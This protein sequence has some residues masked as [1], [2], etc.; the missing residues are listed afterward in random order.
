MLEAEGYF[1]NNPKDTHHHENGVWQLP[2][3]LRGS[4]TDADKARYQE[5]GESHRMTL[6]FVKPE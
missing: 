3:S 6:V 2:P 5:I 4:E 1:N